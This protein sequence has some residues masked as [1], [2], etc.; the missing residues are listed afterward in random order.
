MQY[1]NASLGMVNS[2]D[3][4][5]VENQV[6]VRCLMRKARSLI[7]YAQQPKRALLCFVLAI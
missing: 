1:I 6:F 3:I 4:T 7:E 2:N 5:N